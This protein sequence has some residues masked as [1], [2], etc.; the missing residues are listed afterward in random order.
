MKWQKFK[1]TKDVVWGNQSGIYSSDPNRRQRI[2]GRT[3]IQQ[4]TEV[5]HELR[6]CMSEM[7]V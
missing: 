2:R 6:F 4:M 1:V 7:F 5:E 3:F